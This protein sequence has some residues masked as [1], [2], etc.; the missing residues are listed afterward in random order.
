MTGKKEKITIAL[1]GCGRFCQSFVPLFEK[2][3]SVKKCMYAI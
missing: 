1:I 2:H 3:P